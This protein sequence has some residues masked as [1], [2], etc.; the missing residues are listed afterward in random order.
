MRKVR[1]RKKKGIWFRPTAAAPDRSVQSA[2][3]AEP[4]RGGRLGAPP[5]DRSVQSAF[6]SEPSGSR[7]GAPPLDR[8]VQS[9]FPSEPSGSPRAAP[10]AALRGVDVRVLLPSTGDH[11]ATHFAGWSFFDEVLESGC[12]IFRYTAGFCHQKVALVDSDLALVG[13]ANLDNRSMRLNFELGALVESEQFAA[14]VDAM[15]T[16]DLARSEEVQVGDF[17]RQPLH[18][19]L[20]ARFARLF[21]PIL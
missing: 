21:A 4:R 17:G 14:E 19:R 12:R 13:S 6:K 8:S 2:S 5:L 18:F 3:Q 16:E 20:V 1:V 11:A 15:L 9:A 10:L 7:L